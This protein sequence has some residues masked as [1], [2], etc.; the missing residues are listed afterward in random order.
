M[1]AVGVIPAIYGSTRLPGKPLNDLGGKLVIRHVYE[2]ALLSGSL[3]QVIV[4]TDDHRIA[5]AVRGF[6][7]TAVMTSADHPNGSSRT[8][9][10]VGNTDADIVV[11]IQGDEPFLDPVMIDEV[12]DV[13]SSDTKLPSATLCCRIAP[14]RYDD[15]NVV[16]TVRDCS[17]F[18]L[19]FSRS[20][21]PYPRNAEFQVVYKH[22]GIYGYRR[23][24]LQRFVSLPE[25]PLSQAESLEQLKVL[26]HGYRMKV[27]ETSAAYNA[28]SIDTEAD[29]EAARKHIGETDYDR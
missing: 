3:D 16:K 8:A 25:T 11:N 21:I 29:L 5:D 20:L 23:K 9:E 22:I 24:F 17:G 18:A 27:V 10:A 19:Y 2:R 28:L 15:A 4:A 26:E 14:E 7:G 12:V 6:G 13:L 1:K